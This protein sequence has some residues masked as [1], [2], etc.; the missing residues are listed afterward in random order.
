MPD[1]VAIAGIIVGGIG[2]LSAFFSNRKTKAVARAVREF[3]EIAACFYALDPDGWTDDEKQKL[4]A[5]TID[6]FRACEDA[7]IELARKP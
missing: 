5:A 2:I 7:G 6:F 1:L 4:A 3:A